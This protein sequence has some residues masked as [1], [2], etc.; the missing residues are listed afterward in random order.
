MLDVPFLK[1]K[2][3]TKKYRK[4]ASPA[5]APAQAIQRLN[6]PETSVAKAKRAKPTAPKKTTEKAIFLLFLNTV[7]PLPLYRDI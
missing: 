4:S 2:C 6:C 1:K 7:I 5:T 3:L